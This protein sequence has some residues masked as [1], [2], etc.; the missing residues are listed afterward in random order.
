MTCIAAAKDN[1][2]RVFI[3]G[4]SRCTDGTCVRSDAQPKVFR[5][6][7]FLIGSSGSHRTGQIVE[8]LFEPPEITE[9]DLVAY[10]VKDFAT[11]LRD[12]MRSLGVERTAQDSLAEMDGRL[13]VAIRG[14]IFE[15]DSAYGIYQPRYPYHA[16]GTAGQL[17]IVAMF[18]L[19][20][21][22][23][24]K[25]MEAADLVQAGLTAAARFDIHVRDPFHTLHTEPFPESSPA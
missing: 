16:I 6:G 11:K 12:L 21:L 17:A 5:S 3:G 2:G 22:S 18:A 24:G 10:M 14:N 9:A 8:H 15:V 25:Q 20:D 4:D 23:P 1:Q 13:L 7:E 19:S